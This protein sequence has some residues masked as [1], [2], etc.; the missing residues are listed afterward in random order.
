MV[1]PVMHEAEDVT[2]SAT[3]FGPAMARLAMLL[4]KF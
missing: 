4:T 2:A 3:S 1:C